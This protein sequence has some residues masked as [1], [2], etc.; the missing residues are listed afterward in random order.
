MKFFHTRI[1][2]PALALLSGACAAGKPKADPAIQP[3]IPIEVCII[4]T[5]APGG[6]MTI[7]ALHVRATNDTVILQPEGRVPIARAVAGPRVLAEATWTDAKT[8]IQL[9]GANG[10]VRFA[11]SG[12]PRV[13]NPGKVALLAMMRGAPIFTVPSEG[14]RMRAELE[15]FAARGM[16]LEKAL[17]QRATLRRQLENVQA[18]YIP[19]K[20]VGC[21]FQ[22][23]VKMKVTTRRR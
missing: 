7:G 4:D 19:T 18:L 22:R 13:Q 21:E 8:P 15:S 2:P 10:R 9:A 16:D 6:M 17:Q 23:F 14:G 20:L 1:L 3:D 5:I 11:L 12:S